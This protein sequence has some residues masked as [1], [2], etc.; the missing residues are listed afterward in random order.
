MWSIS[1]P[2][3]RAIQLQPQLFRPWIHHLRMRRMLGPDLHGMLIERNRDSDRLRHRRPNHHKGTKAATLILKQTEAPG[4]ITPA[5]G[6]LRQVQRMPT[7]RD[8]GRQA[9]RLLRRLRLLQR[10]WPLQHL[11]RQQQGRPH[12]RR[13]YPEVDR[14]VHVVRG[15]RQARCAVHSQWRIT[16]DCYGDA[17]DDAEGAADPGQEIWR[18]LRREA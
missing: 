5:R 12:Q 3:R 11:H 16:R 9:R 6:L 7:D 2:I 4:A 10:V 15:G 13:Q 14:A 1:N 18:A 17:G 8:R